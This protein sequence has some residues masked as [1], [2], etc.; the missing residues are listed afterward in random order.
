MKLFLAECLVSFYCG[1]GLLDGDMICVFIKTV[2]FSSLEDFFIG[3]EISWQDLA[4]VSC[5]WGKV[6]AER[7]VIET[8]NDPVVPEFLNGELFGVIGK[9]CNFFNILHFLFILDVNVGRS[10]ETLAAI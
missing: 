10:E 5:L 4:E 9:L 7:V 1:F 3:V 2:D 8:L 6:E